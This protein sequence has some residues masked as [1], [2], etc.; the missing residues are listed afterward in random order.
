M[1]LPSLERFGPLVKRGGL[2]V[3]NASLVPEKE[4]AF[5]GIKRVMVPSR[6]LALE[7]GD[8]RLAN[9]VILGATVKKSAVLEIKALKKALYLALDPRY[10]EMIETNAAALERGAAF[11]EHGA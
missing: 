6:D 1:N 5:K 8:E 7:V 11:V 9:M 4:V 3:V 10:H 2:L